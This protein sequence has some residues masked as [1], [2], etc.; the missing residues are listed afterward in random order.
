M[1]SFTV[2]THPSYKTMHEWEYSL[3]LCGL[4][5]NPPHASRCFL[6][7]QG[8]RTKWSWKDHKGTVVPIMSPT[9]FNP[10]ASWSFSH[11]AIGWGGIRIAPLRSPRVRSLFLFNTHS[12]LSG[13]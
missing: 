2:L 9:S 7:C 10:L 5:K 8:K 3:I 6:Q 13:A 4:H 12:L 11:P 1:M